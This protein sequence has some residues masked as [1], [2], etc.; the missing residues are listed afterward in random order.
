MHIIEGQIKTKNHMVRSACFHA[1]A[2]Y[3]EDKMYTFQARFSNKVIEW[4]LLGMED[5]VSYSPAS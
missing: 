4:C 2:Q 3:C 1:I 5:P